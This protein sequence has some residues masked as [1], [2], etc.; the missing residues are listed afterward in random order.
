MSWTAKQRPGYKARMC[1]PS[2]HDLC[3]THP[4][5]SEATKLSALNTRTCVANSSK[6]CATIA[7]GSRPAVHSRRKPFSACQICTQCRVELK[8]RTSPSTSKPQCH[9]SQLRVHGLASLSAM[10]LM[11]FCPGFNKWT[12]G[13]TCLPC[14]VQASSHPSRPALA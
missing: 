2:T 3:R 14:S 7:M 5:S 11:A 9:D 8:A 13:H 12:L 10:T 4:K 1:I 6:L